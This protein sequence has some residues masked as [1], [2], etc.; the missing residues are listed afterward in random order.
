M[1]SAIS[2]Q[3]RPRVVIVGAGFA[4]V[5]AA[6]ALGKAPVDVVVINRQN[7]HLFEPS[8]TKLRPRLFGQPT[9]HPQSVRSLRGRPTRRSSWRR[10]QGTP[11]LALRADSGFA[12]EALVTPSAK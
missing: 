8:S 5:T 7:H 3:S 6:K 10:S 1:R 12:R 11:V 9:S 2:A 4:G